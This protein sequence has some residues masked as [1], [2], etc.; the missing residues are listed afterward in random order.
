MD[1]LKSLNINLVFLGNNHSMDM[2]TVGL[3]ETILNLKQAGISNIGAGKNSKEAIKPYIFKKNSI[4][5]AIVSFTLVGHQSTYSNETSAGV[6]SFEALKHLKDL[7]NQVDQIIFSVHW[8]NEYYSTPVEI[9]KK[10]A[11]NLIKRYK[12]D[13]IIG[14]HPHIPQ[15]IE[16]YNGKPIIYSLGNFLFGSSHFR[17]EHNILILCEWDKNSQKRTQLEK[18]WI[19]PIY[20]KFQNL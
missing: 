3:Q 12:A 17:L 18:I 15:S 10:W 1:L 2:G 19:I 4:R 11:R 16:I 14:H 13:L 6:A 20:G 7:H 9:Q 5:Y 8:G